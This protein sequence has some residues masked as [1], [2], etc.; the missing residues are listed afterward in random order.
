MVSGGMY[1]QWFTARWDSWAHIRSTLT[2]GFATQ[3]TLLGVVFASVG[4]FQLVLR[5]RPLGVALLLGCV[6]NTAFFWTY[7][8]HDRAVFFMP[9]VTLLFMAL[10]IGLDTSNNLAKTYW[11]RLRTTT[12]GNRDADRPYWLWGLRR[13][14]VH[15]GVA[16]AA[17]LSI[18]VART[19]S[20]YP[21]MDLSEFTEAEDFARAIETQTPKNAFILNYTT[22]PE[23][24]YDA[25]FGFYYHRLHNLRPDIQIVWLPTDA[26][27]QALFTQHRDVFAYDK[28]GYKTNFITEKEGPLYR[29]R[30]AMNSGKVGR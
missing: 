6:G 21:E 13:I 14:S 15:I 16:G 9:S 29:V 25:V 20:S 27:V 7:N 5:R 23:W 24:K 8:V 17:L 22:P 18:T 19:V 10:G 26:Y 3:L 30:P 12:P 1:S 2:T 11:R 4:L 28:L